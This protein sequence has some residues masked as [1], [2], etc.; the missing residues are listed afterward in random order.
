MKTK[1]SKDFNVP[2]NC[3]GDEKDIHG[4]LSYLIKKMMN[5]LKN[6]MEIDLG[7]DY[8]QLRKR[9]P[10][11]EEPNLEEMEAAKEEI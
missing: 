5:R 6:K 2:L 9:I 7:I 3:Y 10:L 11:S 8:E 1:I 4:K